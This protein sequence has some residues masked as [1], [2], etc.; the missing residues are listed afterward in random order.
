MKSASAWS[1]CILAAAVSVEAINLDTICKQHF[2]WTS[3]P[4]ISFGI[5][6]TGLC[7]LK[8]FKDYFRC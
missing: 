4:K 3:N 8:T 6:G 2:T 5:S 1:K 7:L